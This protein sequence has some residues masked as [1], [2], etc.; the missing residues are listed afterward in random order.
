[1]T[2]NRQDAAGTFVPLSDMD[3]DITERQKL[4][5]HFSHP[6]TFS[7]SKNINFLSHVYKC[8]S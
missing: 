4:T 7:N 1:M 6:M 2:I 8:D 5:G 3:T